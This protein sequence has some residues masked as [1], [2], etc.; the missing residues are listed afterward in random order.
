MTEIEAVYFLLD[1]MNKG[2]INSEEY[3]VL[4]Y[5]LIK[6][7][8][9]FEKNYPICA[10][11]INDDKVLIISDTHIGSEYE[12]HYFMSNAYN[13]A[14]NNNIRTVIHLGDLIEGT[15]REN[16]RS[17]SYDDAKKELERAI[18][19]VCYYGIETKLLLGN[20]DFSIINKYA[21]PS[22]Q[23]LVYN[24]F[25]TNR[26]L[27]VL[28]LGRVILDWNGV[29]IKLNHNISEKL[30]TY[31]N[32]DFVSDIDLLGHAHWYYISENKNAISVPS[33]SN[34][35]KDKTYYDSI[36]LQKYGYKL[37]RN[38]PYL[39]FL[40]ARFV[41]DGVILFGEYAERDG[42]IVLNEEIVFNKNERL[43][44]KLG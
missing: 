30:L 14:I 22:F 38:N 29:K 1:K 6:N 28:G 5:F 24:F 16:R 35:L 42:K 31:E 25:A 9:V 18:N 10:T 17:L 33:L 39:N 19:Y 15:V 7:S 2:I 13:Y 43:I 26:L 23:N 4:Q 40:I 37:E 27:S 41:D 11:S 3:K 32:S 36:S 12:N 8:Q 34:E 21:Y 20:H 44:K